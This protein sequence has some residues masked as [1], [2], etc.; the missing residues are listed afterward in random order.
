[1]ASMALSMRFMNT[2][3]SCTRS[4][5]ILGSSAASSVRMAIEYRVASPFSSVSISWIIPFTST[6]SRCGGDFL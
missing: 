1:M 5:M 3:C 4:T 6:N 2:C